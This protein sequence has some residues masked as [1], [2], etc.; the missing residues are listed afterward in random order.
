MKKKLLVAALLSVA[1]TGAMAQSA[2]QGFYGQVGVGYESINVEG[3]GATL[4]VANTNYNF[5]QSFDQSNNFNGTV[6]A[7]YN[8]GINKDFLLGIGAEYSP[9][10]SSSANYSLSNSALGTIS[11]S[12]KKQNAY[13][14]FVSPTI[15]IDKDKAAYFKIGYTGASAKDNADGST[16]NYTGY[17]L[18][19]GYKQIISGG[20]YAFG[21]TNYYKYGDKSTTESGTLSGTSYSSTV[22]S[23]INAMNVM[24]GIGYKF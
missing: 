21:E 11:S 18:G 24:V 23:G 1:A 4:R 5:S 15:V 7:G 13:N 17:S 10:S 12:Y 8:F 14:L 6:T 16:T 3:K 22:S 19:L 9:F 2:F 20:I